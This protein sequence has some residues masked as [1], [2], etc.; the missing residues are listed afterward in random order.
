MSDERKTL[1]A[2]EILD[3]DDAEYA[4]VDVPLWGGTVRLR[5]LTADEAMDFARLS[6]N[7]DGSMHGEMMVYLVEKTAVDEQGD[8]LFSK[9][10]AKGLTKKNFRIFTE[11]QDAALELNKLNPKDSEEKSAV[12]EEKND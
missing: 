9:E 6:S 1:S 4:Y 3:A 10:Q 11:L 8:Q 7:S 5:T 2:Q 12:E